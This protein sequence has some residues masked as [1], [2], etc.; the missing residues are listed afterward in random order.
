[1]STFSRGRD[2]LCRETQNHPAEK[3]LRQE[4][5]AQGKWCLT[6]HPSPVSPRLVRAGEGQGGFKVDG[7]G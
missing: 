6:I 5:S 4:E 3:W 1:M 2:W 7:A